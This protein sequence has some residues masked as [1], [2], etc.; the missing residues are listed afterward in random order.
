MAG[1]H[2]TIDGNTAAAY[3][4]HATNEVVAIYPITPS[5]VMG[6]L[7][8]EYSAHGRTNVW[9]QIPTVVELQSEGGA[10]AA[11]HGAL[12]GGALATTFTASQGLLLMIPNMFKISG[13]LAPTVFHISARS[14]SCQAL[15]IFGDHSDI[16]CARSAG[17]G[18]MLSGSPQEVTDNA[19]V[20]QRAALKSRI[21]FLQAFDGFR[22]S[23]EIQKIEEISSDVMREMID[24]ED[25]VAIRNRALKPETPTM[26]GTAQNPDLYFQGRESV[27]PYYDKCPEIVQEAYDKFAGLTGR[28]YKLFD[29]YGAPDA[30][31]VMVIMGSGADTAEEAVNYMHETECRKCGL[32]K[33]RLYRPFSTMHLLEA[34][35]DTVKVVVAMDR[36]KEPGSDGEPLYLDLN[37]TC[38]EGTRQGKFETMPRVVGG[39][40]GLSSKEFTPAMV[41]AAFSHAW[42]KDPF[43]GFTVGINDDVTHLSLDYSEEIDSEHPSTYRAKFYGLGADGTVGASKNTIKV[44]GEN[45]DK[46]VQGF[47]VYD[48]K[49]AGGVTCSHL[50]FSDELIKSTYLITKPD[51]VAVHAESFLGRID[52]LKGIKEGGSVLINTY[53]PPDKLF[54]S[55]PRREQETIINKKLKLYCIN[56]YEIA[57]GLGI[58][59]RINTTMQAAFFK[60]SGVMPEDVYTNAIEGAISKTYSTK[61]KEV[62]DMNIAAFRKGKELVV[63]VAVPEKITVSGEDLEPIEI[64]NPVIHEFYDE[65][66][67]PVIKQE[68]DDVPV[69]RMPADGAFP[70]ATSQY[71]KRSIATHLP[72]W[73]PEFCIQCGNCSFVCP[74][75]AIRVKV[76]SKSSIELSSDLY[77]TK[78]YKDKQATEND[79]FRVQVFPDD[80]TGCAACAEYCPGKEKVDKK[81]TGRKALEMVLKGEVLERDQETVKEFLRLPETDEKFIRINTAKGTQFKRPLLEFS[82]ACGGCGETPYMKLVTQLFGDRMMQANATGCSSIWGGT[83]PVSPFCVNDRGHGPA[84]SS[85]LFEDSAEFGYGMRLAVNALHAKAYAMREQLLADSEFPGE[86]KDRLAKLHALEE[87]YADP[88]AIKTNQEIVAELEAIVERSNGKQ[89]PKLAYLKEMLPYFVK[90]SVWGVG[91]D[92]WAYDIGYGGLDHVL[93]SGDDVNLLV[94]DTEVYSN[95]GGQRSKA[96]PMSAV[97][98]FA[99]AGKQTAKKDLGLMAMAYRSAYVASVCY[100]AKPG[101]LVKALLEA[102]SFPGTSLIIC[103]SHCIEHGFPLQTIGEQGKLAVES[104]YWPL[105]R[106]DP[107]LIENGEN[108]LQLDMKEPIYTFRDYAMKENRFRRLLREFPEEGEILLAEA[109]LSVHRRWLF[110]KALSEMDYSEF[111]AKV[112][113]AAAAS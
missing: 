93:A 104:G 22:T 106:Y 84:W 29:Y 49:K 7:A 47:F 40:Y 21:P 72:K 20:A 67:D 14:I 85:S 18:I 107:R 41:K 91:G 69:S 31:V 52:V 61:G 8:D 94:L 38:V 102:E 23:H 12:T 53:V 77:L 76:H 27:N 99:S 50:R 101:Q 60:V 25:I 108:P 9:G 45:T 88:T 79:V 43:T 65:V 87:Q 68:G 1:K 6:E 4:A 46:Y 34:L 55:L 3:T 92:G 73:N 75:A 39:R 82:G 70:T 58:P 63:E 112:K 26:R 95:T 113:E 83:A 15:S 44:F 42:S 74:H 62:V 33:V 5:S 10:S 13:E 78:P 110:Y 90:K 11:I 98:K 105:Y 89:A 86:V 56:A 81:E 48:S 57:K 30:E 36:T 37:N 51:F 109:E 32:I 28:Q 2:V 66:I 103:Y 97:A 35:P 19:L 100:S 16:M 71:E 54:D 59:G 96:T 17:F 64:E 24:E 80:C 111:A